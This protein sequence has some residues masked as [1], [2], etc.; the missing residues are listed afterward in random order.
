MLLYV[1]SCTQ[2]GFIKLSWHRVP[3]VYYWWWYFPQL[4]LLRNCCYLTVPYRN[5][6][7]FSRNSYESKQTITRRWWW[8]W[9]EKCSCVETMLVHSI[10]FVFFCPKFLFDLLK[11]SIYLIDIAF[12]SLEHLAFRSIFVSHHENIYFF[13]IVFLRFFPSLY[14]PIDSISKHCRQ[15]NNFFLAIFRLHATFSLFVKLFQFYY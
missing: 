1:F 2:N 9:C 8:Y 14:Q 5:P 4:A 11:N 7:F 10:I 15:I 3:F 6:L 12:L 13:R